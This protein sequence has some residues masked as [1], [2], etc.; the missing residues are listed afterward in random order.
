MKHIAAVV[1]MLT[2]FFMPV[3]YSADTNSAAPAA[4]EVSAE[5][6]HLIDQ[7][8]MLTGAAKMADLFV[9]VYVEQMA[10]VLQ[11]EQPDIDPKAFVVMRDVID[12]LIREEIFD[13]KALN[14]VSYPVYDQYFTAE[15]LGKLVEFYQTPVGRKTI[16]VL[17]IVTQETLNAAKGWGQTLGPKIQQRLM[18]RFK[19]E[20]IELF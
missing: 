15:D 4:H 9:N 1:A 11:E 16:M 2:L 13:K 12:S 20:G 5:K 3:A 8:L 7:L 17:P 6:K 19:A 18:A 14:K 10:I